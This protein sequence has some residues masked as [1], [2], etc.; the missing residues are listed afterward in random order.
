MASPIIFVTGSTEGIGKATAAE[1]LSRG[2]EVIIHSRNSLLLLMNYKNALKSRI[3]SA[4]SHI[5]HR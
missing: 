3:R 1:L 2:A 4:Y 5:T